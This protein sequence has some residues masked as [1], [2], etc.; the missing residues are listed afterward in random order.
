MEAMTIT[1]RDNSRFWLALAAGLAAFVVLI[2]LGS[3]QVQRLAWKN[4]LLATI[5]ER[6]HSE[7]LPLAEVEDRFE[8]TGDVEY[9]PV[10]AEGRF[11]HDGERHFFATHGG[12]SGY[13]VYTPL[14]L[15]DGRYVFVNRGFVPYDRKDPATRMEGQTEG[16]VR[17]AGLARNPLAEKPSSIVPD[18]EPDKNIFYWKDRDAMAAT[19]G[20]ADGSRVLPFFIDADDGPNPGGL[21]VGG[22]TIIDLPNNHLQYAVTWYGLAAALVAVLGA[23]LWRNRK[24]A[25]GRP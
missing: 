19:S 12:A 10:R 1:D 17:V 9:Q 22:V 15:D 24:S 2:G 11:V 13:Y 20:L 3:W 23:Y 25:S 5:D 18:N 8:A 6:V 4:T 16:R 14:M 21:P 7:A